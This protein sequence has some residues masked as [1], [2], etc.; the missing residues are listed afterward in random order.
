MKGEGPVKSGFDNSEM[1]RRAAADRQEYFKESELREKE[2]RFA[3]E[4]LA[5]WEESKRREILDIED[6]IN[7]LEASDRF[8]YNRISS[9]YNQSAEDHRNEIESLKERI[10]N[11][12]FKISKLQIAIDEIKMKKRPR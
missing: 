4:E 12:K 11:N 6:Q 2:E 5:L 10:E 8:S 1:L 3:K 9:L 7:A